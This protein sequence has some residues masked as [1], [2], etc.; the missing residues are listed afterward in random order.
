MGLHPASYRRTLHPDPQQRHAGNRCALPEGCK[1]ANRQLQAELHSVR[2]MRP[3]PLKRVAQRQ[4][5]AFECQ[6]LIGG[7]AAMRTCDIGKDG[8]IA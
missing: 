4:N 5:G 2:L 1:L 6:L 7:Q 3:D 8:K